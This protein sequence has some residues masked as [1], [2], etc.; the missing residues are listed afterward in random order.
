MVL[1]PHPVTVDLRRL[2]EIVLIASSRSRR[3]LSRS[4]LH[5]PAVVRCSTSASWPRRVGVD[6]GA[7]PRPGEEL[8]RCAVCFSL[9]EVAKP[10]R[11]RHGTALFSHLLPD[12]YNGV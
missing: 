12:A 9:F 8:E 1:L 5:F 7:L 10:F 6:R 11:L 2:E 3:I 4:F